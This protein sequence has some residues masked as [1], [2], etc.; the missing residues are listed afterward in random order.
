MSTLLKCMKLTIF[1]LIFILSLSSCHTELQVASDTKCGD[2]RLV[3]LYNEP[4]GLR[5]AD[6]D[7]LDKLCAACLNSAPCHKDRLRELSDAHRQLTAAEQAELSALV[8]DCENW[9]KVKPV[10]PGTALA[11]IALPLVVTA[12]AAVVYFAVN[13][14]GI[15]Y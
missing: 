10:S 1:V 3:K 7:T 4:L 13:L 2:I 15:G 8:I 14:P 11:W 9:Q 12:L 6:Q 5:Q